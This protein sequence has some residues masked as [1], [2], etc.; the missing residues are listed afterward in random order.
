MQCTAGLRLC[1]TSKVP[2]PPPGM[3]GV[4]ATSGIMLRIRTNMSHERAQQALDRLVAVGGIA[5]GKVSRDT[6]RLRLGTRRSQ[7]T[8]RGRIV[9]D[10]GGTLVCAWPCPP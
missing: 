10:G 3:H 9:P 2:G 7:V 4:S 5:R 8:L 1:S 6:F